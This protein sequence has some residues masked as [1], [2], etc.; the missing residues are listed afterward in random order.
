MKNALLF[1]LLLIP[2]VSFAR[3]HW[4]TD[5]HFWTAFTVAEGSAAFDYGESQAAF[6]RGGI[7]HNSCFGSRRPSFVRMNV[8]DMGLI[9]GESFA[10]YRLSRSEHRVMRD[11]WIA[12]V[13][14]D[15]AY[16]VSLGIHNTRVCRQGCS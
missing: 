13:L 11:S 10:S 8:I 3:P 7:E 2:S 16:H 12:P 9:L 14:P 4:Y 5:K 15:A 1:I 6:D